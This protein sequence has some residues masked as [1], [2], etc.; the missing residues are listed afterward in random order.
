MYAVIK[1][2]G[3]QYRVSPGDKVK[4]EKL[5]LAEGDP[6]V[7]SDVLMV[8]DGSEVKVGS[9]AVEGAEVK[10]TVMGH[11]RGKK[12]L[13][14]KFKKRKGFRKRQGHRQDYTLVR[15]DEVSSKGSSKPKASKEGPGEE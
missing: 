13:V 15:I 12:V 5:G 1:T 11:G 10:G 9:P 3:K 14:F 2:G 8:S 7:F 6:V 4:V